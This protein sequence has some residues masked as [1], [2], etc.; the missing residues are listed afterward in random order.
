MV[1]VL[2]PLEQEGTEAV[3]STWLRAI[4]DMVSEN[5]P[6]LE[7]ETDKVSVEV[8]APASGRIAE[9]LIG[10]GQKALPG[11]VLARIEAAGTQPAAEIPAPG[12]AAAPE[13]RSCA[14]GRDMSS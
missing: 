7:L 2:V 13:A 3:V 10:A 8:P 11:A 1:D 6:L 5:D 14:Q 12:R 9:I 4:G